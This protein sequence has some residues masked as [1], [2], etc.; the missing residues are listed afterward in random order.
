[1]NILKSDNWKFY[2]I[3]AYHEKLDRNKEI[4]NKK[5]LQ[6]KLCLTHALQ[7]ATKLGRPVALF[8]GIDNRSPWVIRVTTQGR[9][10][11]FSDNV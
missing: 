11:Y 10:D 1:M 9:R 6:I 8:C 3:V 7:N 5:W 2:F 4:N